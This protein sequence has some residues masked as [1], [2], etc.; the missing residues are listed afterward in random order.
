MSGNH[1]VKFWH[2]IPRDEILWQPLVQSCLCDGCGLCV[3]SCP[4]NALSFDFELK[5]PFVEPMRCLVGCSICASIC[6]NQAILIPDF[7]TLKDIIECHHLE[8]TARKEL[9][10]H[11]RRY[12]SMLPQAY[13]TNDLDDLHN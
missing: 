12:N 13:G 6:P 11:R 7:Q 9:K 2:G 5:L 1:C 4:A 10:S 8:V 3:T